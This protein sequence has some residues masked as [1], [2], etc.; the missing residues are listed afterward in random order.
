MGGRHG[1]GGWRTLATWMIP[2]FIV[3]VA[4]GSAT[5]AAPSSPPLSPAL[6][7]FVRN[8]ENAVREWRAGNV[9]YP[10]SFRV[11]PDQT[12]SYL[13]VVDVRDVPV[14]APTALPG[15]PNPQSQPVAVKCDVAARLVAVD[16]KLEV[17]TTGWVPRTFTPTGTT[18]WTWSVKATG[19]GSSQL[20]LEIEPAIDLRNG[21][22]QVS[23]NDPTIST[24]VTDVQI[25]GSPLQ[26]VAS[27]IDDNK[28]AVG[29]IAAAIVGAAAFVIR[30]VRRLRR[31]SRGG[32]A[33]SDADRDDAADD[34]ADSKA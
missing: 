24:Y 5:S 27:W 10:G 2:A 6:D 13:A 29:T 8:C 33:D 14:P 20:R 16:D 26:R 28:V 9:D 11:A 25:T 12:F 23:D 1:T 15:L 30:A 34:S 31:E 21:Y 7:S 19:D 22:P 4:C 17:S 32:D 18:N 3:L